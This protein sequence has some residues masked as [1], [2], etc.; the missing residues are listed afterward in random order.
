MLHLHFTLTFVTILNACT[1]LTFR[2]CICLFQVVTNHYPLSL[3]LRNTRLVFSRV[4]LTSWR[5]SAS[6]SLKGQPCCVGVTRKITSVVYH[7]LHPSFL[8]PSPSPP[9]PPPSICYW[10]SLNW[11]WIIR[12]VKAIKVSVSYD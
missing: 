10:T 3:W 4:S 7:L 1:T 2:T 12:S 11:I 6:S 9:V 5:E 8:H